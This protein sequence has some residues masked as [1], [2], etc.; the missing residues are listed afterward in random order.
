MLE[1]N[2]RS[3]YEQEEIEDIS[4]NFL[5][6]SNL[7]SILEAKEELSSHKTKDV[8]KHA[9]LKE[10][11]KKSKDEN[12][13]NLIDSIIKNKNVFQQGISSKF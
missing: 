11:E 7:K 8:Q 6:K 12:T 2:Y 9:F 10:K 4:H 5:S 13:R 3:K 1:Q